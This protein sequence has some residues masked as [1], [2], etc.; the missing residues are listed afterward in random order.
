MNDSQ[1]KDTFAALQNLDTVDEA[2]Q[3]SGDSAAESSK[4]EEQQD[5]SAADSRNINVSAI[6][7]EE[8]AGRAKRDYA[9]L[10]NEKPQVQQP[11]YQNVNHTPCNSN[12][13]YVNPSYYNNNFQSFTTQNTQL[14]YPQQGFAQPQHPQQGFA[15]PQHPQQ[16]FAQSQYP[17]QVF[18]QQPFQNQDQPIHQSQVIQE[19]VVV[20][21][22]RW[23]LWITIA[24][25]AVIF[26]VLVIAGGIKLV[27]RLNEGDPIIGRYDLNDDI[28]DNEYH[29]SNGV[30]ASELKK[31]KNGM[32]YAHVSK[33]IGG[34]GT[35]YDNG[36]T[37]LGQEYFT[38]LW[39]GE[40]KPDT[41]VYIT[42]ENYVVSDIVNDGV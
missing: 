11:A 29:F 16:G 31:I 42:F 37:P 30:S 7:Q 21:K 38:Y 25:I 10:F 39:I 41:Y 14:Q 26:M 6:S 19:N 8:E 40:D 4:A 23:P 9:V 18:T 34:D 2:P 32:S 15:Q 28:P 1:E 33:I 27:E 17:Q 5:S 22:K 13:Y 35:L 36:T 3:N 12:G 24:S 20:K